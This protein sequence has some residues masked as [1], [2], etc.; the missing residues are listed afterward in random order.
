MIEVLRPGPLTT[1]QDGG[2][3]GLAHLGVPAAGPADWLSHALANRLVGNADG[4][5]ALEITLTGPTLRCGRDVALAVVGAAVAVDGSAAPSGRTLFVR[6]GQRIAIGRTVGA[7]GYAAVAGGFTVPVT[8]GSRSTD[9]LSGLGPTPLASGDVLPVSTMDTPERML[10][11]LP[12]SDVVRV[13]PGPRGDWVEVGAFFGATFTVTPD[14]DRVG[15]R[16]DGPRI[17]RSRTGELPTEGMVAGAIQVPPDGRPIL[18]LANHAAT[19]G[20]P[21][22]GVVARADLPTAGQL[23][24]GGAVRFAP[25]D[26]DAA[27]RAYA[28]LRLRMD[29]AVRPGRAAG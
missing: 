7:R 19:G 29:R 9:T 10:H 25:I 3:H 22:L 15:V 11:A 28:D 12:R 27:V 13:V 26:R 20:Y 24:P 8:L 5:A 21:V 17:A 2:R 6:A 18:L 23:R 14:S 4:A 1:V 16:L